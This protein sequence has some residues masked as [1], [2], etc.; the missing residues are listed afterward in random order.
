[1]SAIAFSP[2]AAG[3][4]TKGVFMGRFGIMAGLVLLFT[5][6]LMAQDQRGVVPEDS[7]PI[8]I[9]AGYTFVSYREA[10]GLTTNNSGGTAT[11]I[12]YANQVGVEADFTDTY[13]SYSGKTANLLFAGGG[14]RYR[15]PHYRSFEPWIHG[16]VGYSYISPKLSYGANNAFG[17]KV[18][19]GFDINPRHTRIGYRVSGD[20]IGTHFFSTYQMS[21]EVTVGIFFKLHPKW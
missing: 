21:P 15:L 5:T 20:M 11:A 12:Y 13:G 19:G 16:V 4:G 18:G 6:S 1:M 17:Y 8:E 10:P 9:A 14:I 7:H 2:A 3:G